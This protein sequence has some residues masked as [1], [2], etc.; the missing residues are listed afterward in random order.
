MSIRL[1]LTLLYT[2][3]LGLTVIAFSTIL[4]VT[5]TR[6][7]YDSIQADLVR[8]AS[9]SK[10]SERRPP[11]PPDSGSTPTERPPEL[12]FPSGAL[13]AGGPRPAASPEP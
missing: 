10:D 1:R 8:Q 11:R 3:I 4:F 13:P 5:Q 2:A 9:F 7:T 12:T 6:A